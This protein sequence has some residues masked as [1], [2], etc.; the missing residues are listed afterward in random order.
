MISCMFVARRNCG[1]YDNTRNAVL[2][3]AVALQVLRDCDEDTRWQRH[4]EYSVSL[5]AAF[6]KLA[7]MLLELLEGLIL[8]ILP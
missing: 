3:V 8:V 7:Q 2:W 1:T 5:L 4:V 6:L